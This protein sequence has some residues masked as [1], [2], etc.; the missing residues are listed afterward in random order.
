MTG[1]AEA[2]APENS[3]NPKIRNRRERRED[4]PAF[5]ENIICTGLKY[6]TIKR[7][8]SHKKL[9]SPSRQRKIYS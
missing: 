5:E 2:N 7:A 4:R 6:R 1:L 9:I 8:N 3:M